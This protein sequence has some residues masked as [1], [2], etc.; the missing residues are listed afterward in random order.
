MLVV[1]VLFVSLPLPFSLI[2]DETTS[3]DIVLFPY[4]QQTQPDS[5][6]QENDTTNQILSEHHLIPEPW[7]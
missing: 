4:R 2:Q 1:S 3:P 5:W 6:A 7:Y